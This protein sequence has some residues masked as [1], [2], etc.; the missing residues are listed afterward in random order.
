[1]R[2]RIGSRMYDTD[3]ARLCG[4][5][6]TNGMPDG[7]PAFVQENLYQ[8]R[9][10]EFFLVVSR[11]L[12]DSAEG[13]CSVEPMTHQQAKEWAMERWSEYDRDYFDYFGESNLTRRENVAL[14]V[15]IHPSMLNKIRRLSEESGVSV[16]D[17]VEGLIERA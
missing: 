16:S 5:T 8:K 9:T 1:M 3:S 6:W 13:R 4:R 17:V 12:A 15:R 7:S 11:G 14:Q 2:K 10:G